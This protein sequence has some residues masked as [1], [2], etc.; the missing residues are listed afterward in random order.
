MLPPLY[1]QICTKQLSSS[2]LSSSLP[3]SS[4]SP[5]PSLLLKNT[6]RDRALSEDEEREQES[7]AQE[8]ARKRDIEIEHIKK[9]NGFDTQYHEWLRKML[10]N[11]DIGLSHNRISPNSIISDGYSLSLTH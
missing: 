2:S 4:P 9:H 1:Y 6:H 11:D 10:I 8:A 5:S 7:K 3:S